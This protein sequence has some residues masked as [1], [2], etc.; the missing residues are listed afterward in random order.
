MKQGA[1]SGELLSHMGTDAQL[2]AQEFRRIYRDVTTVDADDAKL[3]EG[4]LIG[5]FANAIMAGWDQARWLFED[6]SP[7]DL[8][9][10]DSALITALSHLFDEYGPLGVRKAAR[11]LSDT[12]K[13]PSL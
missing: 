8:H 9:V 5:W 11:A 1:T 10:T 6:T 13:V 7:A 3:D 12:L 2:W 4:W